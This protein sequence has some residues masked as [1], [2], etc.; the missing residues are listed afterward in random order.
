MAT[1]K[2]QKRRAKRMVHGTPIDEERSERTPARTR[3][4]R[5][6]APPAKGRGRGL[7]LRAGQRALPEPSWQRSLKRAAIFLPVIIGL[8]YIASEER[9]VATIAIPA[10]LATALFVPVDFWT[11]KMTQRMVQKRGAKRG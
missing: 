5:A 6:Q 2:Q 7:G 3:A 10:L 11:A 9:T 4:P 8:F 1:R